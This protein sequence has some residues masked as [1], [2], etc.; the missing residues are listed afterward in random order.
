[1]HI[2]FQVIEAI[3]TIRNT[4]YHYGKWCSQFLFRPLVI[5]TVTTKQILGT[6]L[7]YD[8]YNDTFKN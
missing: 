2:D 7:N 8:H 6:F 5:G 4:K 1:M 3:T